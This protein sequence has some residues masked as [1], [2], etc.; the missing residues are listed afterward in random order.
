MQETW[1]QFLGWED[2]LEGGMSTHSSVLA[3]R[4]PMNRGAWQAAVP[5]GWNIRLCSGVEVSMFYFIMHTV[6]VVR[7]LSRVRLCNPVNCS[8]PGFPVIPYLSL[9]LVYLF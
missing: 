9:S 7:S 3:W 4:I 2:P 1:V 6:V 5:Y 8:T